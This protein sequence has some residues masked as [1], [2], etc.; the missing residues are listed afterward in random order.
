M[1]CEKF[2]DG[3][4]IMAVNPQGRSVASSSYREQS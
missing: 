4:T 1:V 2:A 3:S